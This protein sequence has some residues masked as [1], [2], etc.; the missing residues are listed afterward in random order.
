VADVRNNILGSVFNFP[1]SNSVANPADQLLA[2][3][4]ILPQMMQVSK[5]LDGVGN[6]TANPNYNPSLRSALLGSSYAANFDTAGSLLRSPR[7][8]PAPSTTAPAPA[9]SPPATSPITDNGSGGGNWLFGN[10]NQNGK[11]DL[12][13]GRLGGSRCPGQA[14]RQRRGVD[15][16]GGTLNTLRCPDWRHRWRT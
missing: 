2:T 9:P 12:R 14:L 16:N 13:L 4:F 11:R 1:A 10:F 6:T 8:P 5:P 7:A 15:A 3:S